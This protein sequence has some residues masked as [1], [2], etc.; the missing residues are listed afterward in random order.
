M[1]KV[2]N[3]QKNGSAEESR[4]MYDAQRGGRQ[5]FSMFMSEHICIMVDLSDKAYID[6]SYIC[7]PPSH[8][9]IAIVGRASAD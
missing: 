9:S 3:G 2:T 8:A 1:A 4:T 7:K 5:L 6:S